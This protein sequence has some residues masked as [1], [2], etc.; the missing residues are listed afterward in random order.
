M[1]SEKTLLTRYLD[2]RRYHFQLL[3]LDSSYK[4]LKMVYTNIETSCQ[5]N[6]FRKQRTSSCILIFLNQIKISQLSNDK[7]TR[8]IMLKVSR[9]YLQIYHHRSPFLLFVNSHNLYHCNCDQYS[10]SNIKKKKKLAD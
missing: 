3:T 5:L 10:F 9:I 2:I 1:F 4:Y 8:K 6:F 7:I